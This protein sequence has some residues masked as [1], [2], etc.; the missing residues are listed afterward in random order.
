M[1]FQPKKII[2][3][4]NRYKKRTRQGAIKT[5]WDERKI[6]KYIKENICGSVRGDK[7]GGGTLHQKMS[8][9]SIKR[10]AL[11]KI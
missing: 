10:T 4:I 11:Y 9:I 1:C 7:R 8:V 2:K 3:R 5:G 6:T